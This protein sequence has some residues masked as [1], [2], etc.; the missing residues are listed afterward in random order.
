MVRDAFQRFQRAA[1]LFAIHLFQIISISSKMFVI[2]SNEWMW[3][4]AIRALLDMFWTIACGESQMAPSSISHIKYSFQFHDSQTVG[5]HCML[6]SL[7]RTNVGWG[8]A[9]LLHFFFQFNMR[10]VAMKTESKRSLWLKT[11]TAMRF[12]R[13]FYF[14]FDELIE[15]VTNFSISVTTGRVALGHRRMYG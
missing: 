9:L 8:R 15:I 1:I 7:T 11:E 4:D 5:K 2:L 3:A 6:V 14:R 10:L 12:E 13:L